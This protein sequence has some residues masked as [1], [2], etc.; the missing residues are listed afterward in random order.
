M[1]MTK[2]SYPASAG[3]LGGTLYDTFR[4]L[5]YINSKNHEYTTRDGHLKGVL[6]DITV[7]SSAD[8]YCYLFAGNNTWKLRNSVRKFHFLREHMFRESGVKK[9]EMGTY[10][11][12]MRP[13]FDAKHADGDVP[14]QPVWAFY[15]PTADALSLQGFTGG[16]W[17]YSQ[18]ATVPTYEEQSGPETVLPEVNEWPAHLFDASVVDLTSPDGGADAAVTW[19]S[20]GMI[21]AYNM[22]RQSVQTQTDKTS[23]DSPNNPLAALA[24]AG[25][26]ATG[27]I[28]DIAEDQELELPPYDLNDDGDSVHFQNV[29]FRQFPNTG[30]SFTFR[31]VFL[32]A[33]YMRVVA[34]DKVGA[35]IT[36][37]IDIDV[38][39]EI[40][41]RELA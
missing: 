24:G 30:G 19:E 27:A 38:I 6:C 36:Y 33:G 18:Y 5:S 8:G 3:T 21:H 11:K 10:G 39:A 35:A 13:Y 40:E 22:D 2:I 4:D 32:P 15:D 37:S 31:N 7:S 23:L 28:V 17:T 25:N 12:T 20:V 14:D 29:G 41:C 16:E 26:Q 34:T 1:A 9:S